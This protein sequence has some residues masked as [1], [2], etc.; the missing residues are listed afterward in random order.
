MNCKKALLCF[1][2]LKLPTT[3]GLGPWNRLNGMKTKIISELFSVVTIGGSLGLFMNGSHQKWHRLGREAFLARES[4]NF[5][6]IYANPAPAV[7]LVLVWLLFALLL[8]A[9]Y[10]CIAVIAAKILSSITR[11]N[12][13]EQA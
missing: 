2:L 12:A 9:L 3:W 13:T 4:Q 11:N 10:K 5:D 8:Y 7:H 6:K 1:S